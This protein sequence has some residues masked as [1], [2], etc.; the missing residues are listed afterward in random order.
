MYKKRRKKNENCLYI[1]YIVIYLYTFV[2]ILWY[3]SSFRLFFFFFMYTSICCCDRFYYLLNKISWFLCYVKYTSHI[4]TYSYIYTRSNGPIFFIL[5]IESKTTVLKKFFFIY[6]DT[7]NY[8][9]IIFGLLEWFLWKLLFSP[10]LKIN[11]LLTTTLNG[12]V[13]SFVSSYN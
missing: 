7:E 9:S 1:I 13:H 3:N 12:V 10:I 11:K 4:H 8:C 6:I 5:I 2:L